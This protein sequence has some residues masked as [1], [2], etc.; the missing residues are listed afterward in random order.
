MATLVKF[1]G[2]TRP[3]DMEWALAHGVDAVGV[4]VEPSSPRFQGPDSDIWSVFR[5]ATAQ[6]V[7]VFGHFAPERMADCDVV[8]AVDIPNHTLA[9]ERWWT[10]RP[11]TLLEDWEGQAAQ[12]QRVLVDA[13]APG[14][15]GGTGHRVDPEEFLA[16]RAQSPVPCILAG[17]LNPDNVYDVVRILRPVMVDLASG[18]EFEPGKKD[19]AKMQA[20]LD[21]V[22]AADRARNDEDHC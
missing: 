14:A 21:A 3:A 6:R 15:Y 22:R 8:Q 4:V 17:G 11:S 12:V 19:P 13:L 9:A 2:F 1:C 18:I 20:F 7:L 16:V 5:A 10:V